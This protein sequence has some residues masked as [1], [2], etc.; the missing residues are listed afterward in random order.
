L[1]IYEGTTLLAEVSNSFDLVSNTGN[2]AM[3][4]F[5]TDIE[6]SSGVSYRFVLEP[7]TAQNIQSYYLLAFGGTDEANTMG[8]GGLTATTAATSGGAW[9]DTSNS[10]Y[11][12]TPVIAEIDAG[13]SGGVPLIGPGGLVY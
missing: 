12:I 7:N 3:Q 10:A 2:P 1:G 4:V 5:R 13:S 11:S 9:T 6:L 8:Y